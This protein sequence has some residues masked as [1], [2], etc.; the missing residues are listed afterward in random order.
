[1]TDF[2]CQIVLAEDL[3]DLQKAQGHFNDPQPKGSHV[4]DLFAAMA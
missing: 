4:P 2:N 3:G 1:M